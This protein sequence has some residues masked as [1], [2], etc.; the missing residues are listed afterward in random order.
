MGRSFK[1]DERSDVPSEAARLRGEILDT[2]TARAAGEPPSENARRKAK[3]WTPRYFI[4]RTAWHAL[5]H[6]WEIED[7]A[8]T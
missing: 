5:D 6:A 2:L 1:R 7:R 3:V 8:E 4:R